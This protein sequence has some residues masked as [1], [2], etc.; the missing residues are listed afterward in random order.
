M[1]RL[2]AF[3]YLAPKTLAEAS[4]MI[5]DAGPDGMLVSG[6]TDLFPNMK[7]LQF[8]PRILVGL[9][10]LSE[11][12]GVSGDPHRGM[13]IGA[14]TP[15]HQLG[16]HP[17]IRARYPAL[18]TAAGSVAT[19]QIRRMG[20]LGGNL[21]VD[22]RCN[23]YNQSY[24]WRRAIGFCMKRDGDV[25]LVAP[26]S[27]RC[28]AVSSSDT[29]PAMMALQATV[30]LSGPDG[31]RTLPVAALYHDDG[32]AYLAKRPEEILTAI[33]LPPV[34]GLRNTYWKL[35]RRGSFDFPILGVAAS[36]RLDGDGTCTDARIVLGAVAS[37]PVEAIEAEKLLLGQRLTSDLIEEAAMAAYRPAKPLDNT[38]LTLAYRKRMARVFVARALRELA[39]LP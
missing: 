34:D 28:V 21:C 4:R 20:T 27:P 12:L 36:L 29:A 37:R 31:E 8:D 39:N 13:R 24:E 33:L 32:M 19:P 22:T 26:G 7:R 35:R 18:A 25:C 9:R 11:L 3:R 6:G 23:Y 17:A 2:P 38:D 15:L 14:A 16:L 1:M 5:A 30:V 10:H